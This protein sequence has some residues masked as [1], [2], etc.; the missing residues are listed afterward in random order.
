MPFF[1]F[2]E[3]F[4][5]FNPSEQDIRYEHL[6]KNISE[7]IVNLP[8]K[9]LIKRERAWTQKKKDKKEK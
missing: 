9:K 4:Q 2:I 3:Q 7:M 6:V 1:K 8:D 5:S